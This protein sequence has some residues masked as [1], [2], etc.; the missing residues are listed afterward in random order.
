MNDAIWRVFQ[1][2][3]QFENNSSN[4]LGHTHLISVSMNLVLWQVTSPEIEVLVMPL[5]LQKRSY[6]SGT[7]LTDWQRMNRMEMVTKVNPKLSSC[8]CCRFLEP[9]RRQTLLRTRL[10]NSVELPKDAKKKFKRLS[11]SACHH[12]HVKKVEP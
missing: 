12:K 6:K 5:L 2:N 10:Q 11:W 9:L 8:C 4:W 7:I 1:V 3:L